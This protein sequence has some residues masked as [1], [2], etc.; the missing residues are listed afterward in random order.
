M[1]LLAIAA[2]LA[3]LSVPAWAINK[4]A[5]T[6]GHVV[7]QD[8]PCPGQGET[9]GEE[10]ARREKERKLALA[11]QKKQA[12]ARAAIEAKSPKAAP[13]LADAPDSE[14]GYGYSRSRYRHRGRR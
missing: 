10:L 4:C 8:K 3:V 9:V 11:Q 12:E 5:E 13:P 2:A 7:F 14:G 1:K 6:D